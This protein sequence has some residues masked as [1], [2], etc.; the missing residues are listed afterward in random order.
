MTHREA[1][2]ELLLEAR[3]GDSGARDRL[4]AAVYDDLRRIA[5]RQLQGERPDHTFGTTGLV[6]ETYMKLA[7]LDRMEWQD[8]GQF[9]R[10]AAGAMRR[11]L[12]DYARKHRA[13]RRGAVSPNDFLDNNAPAAQRGDL[14][15]AVD[16]AL[17]R[18][19][20]LSPRM[21]GVVECRFF[22]GLIEEET[23]EVLGVSARTVQREWVKSRAWLYSELCD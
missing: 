5:H 8:R 4:Y 14:L 6:H 1:I 23:A 22:G 2:T 17:E 9:F 7:D 12:V 15:V 3:G 20:G 18:L 21:S 13:A 19:A 11:I 10:A 16:E